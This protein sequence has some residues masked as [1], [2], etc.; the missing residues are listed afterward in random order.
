MK[1]PFYLEKKWNDIKLWWGT[2]D[3]KKVFASVF[4]IIKN[5]MD[6]IMTIATVISV[7]LVYYTLEEMK[8]ERQNAYRPYI[9]FDTISYVIQ[10]SDDMEDFEKVE[11]LTVYNSD[12]KIKEM[13]LTPELILNTKNIGVGTAKDISISI[14]RESSLNAINA[15]NDTSAYSDIVCCEG[16]HG[17]FAEFSDGTFDG[18]LYF[19]NEVD[20]A[21]LLP[22]AQDEFEYS[23]PTV[24]YTLIEA[25]RIEY[26]HVYYDP[27]TI[28]IRIPDIEIFI[29][30]SDVQGIVYTEKAYIHTEPEWVFYGGRSLECS[31]ISEETAKEY[32]RELEE[33]FAQ[34]EPREPWIIETEP[35]V[36]AMG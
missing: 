32:A 23:L 5:G 2:Q 17:Y 4:S 28:G 22:N 6:V 13:N 25:L 11:G 16:I 3:M 24:Y 10:T 33:L 20:I 26:E 15:F 31:I 27:F 34:Q 12:P 35:S 8:T 7:V 9:Q 21:Y 36:E 29:T 30:Y 1:K 19:E 18:A 14:S